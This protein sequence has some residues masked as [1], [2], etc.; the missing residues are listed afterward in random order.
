[1]SGN[2]QRIIGLDVVRAISILSVI[3]G[4]SFVFFESVSHFPFLG[5]VTPQLSED[6]LNFGIFGVELFFVLSGFLIGGILVRTFDV[7]S[8]FTFS[9]VRNFWVRRWFRTL[10]NYWLI[11]IACLI[12]YHVILKWDPFQ[13]QYLKGFFF[14]QN[15][16]Y[17][18]SLYALPEGWSLSVEEWFYLTLPMVIYLGNRLFRSGNK[19]KFLLKVIMGYLLVFLLIRFFNAF[20]PL[21]GRDPD[22]GIRKVVL[23]RLD[24]VMYGMLIAWFNY[25]A[26]QALNRVKYQLLFICLFLFTVIFYL[27]IHYRLVFM[28]Q[29]DVAI[30][31]VRNAFLY[32]F[33]PFSLSLCLPYANSIRAVKPVFLSSV[34][35][36]ISKISYSMYLVHFSLIYRPFYMQMKIYDFGHALLYYMLYWVIVVVLSTVVYNFFEFPVMNLRDRLGP[37]DGK[38][39]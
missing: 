39:V 26:P 6:I 33:T 16:R 7:S 9:E 15:L 10:P 22:E 21:N 34:I 28:V 19:R 30:R 37:R 11:L 13:L 8:D 5:K 14:L 31:F 20:H 2:N 27:C 29:D 1:M 18:N 24:A 3:F 12:L 17:P 36:H 25:Y 4:H 38:G 23:F 32:L 35:T